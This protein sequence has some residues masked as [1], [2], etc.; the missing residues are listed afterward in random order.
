LIAV[1]AAVNKIRNNR[2]AAEA[3]V[4]PE[5]AGNDIQA[6]VIEEVPVSE[7]VDEQNQ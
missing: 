2:K 5:S 6:E 1:P 3:A 4:T 7:V